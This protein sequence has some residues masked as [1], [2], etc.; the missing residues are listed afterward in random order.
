M[1]I[2]AEGIDRCG[3]T[4]QVQKLTDY[5]LRQG[6]P[7]TAGHAQ[8]IPGKSKEEVRRLS[9]VYYGNLIANLETQPNEVKIWDR[10]HLGEA[11]YSPL[12]RNYSGD[13]VFDYE[14]THAMMSGAFKDV[15][16]FFIYDYIGNV[17]KRDDGLGFSSKEDDIQRELDLFQRAFTLSKIP[18]KLMINIGDVGDEQKVFELILKFIGEKE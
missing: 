9:E 13:Y 3:K 17:I 18:N 2:I 10:A 15:Y 8:K 5:F 16:L 1:T 6:I 7:V 12:Y 11:V 4:T 14:S